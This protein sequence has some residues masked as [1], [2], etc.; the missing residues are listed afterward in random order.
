MVKRTTRF[1]I[2]AGFGQLHVSVD[3]LDDIG[4]RQEV[5]DEILG[6]RPAITTEFNS[7]ASRLRDGFDPSY[8]ATDRVVLEREH[9]VAMMGRNDAFASSLNQTESTSTAL[10]RWPGRSSF[11]K[12]VDG[13]GLPRQLSHGYVS[14]ATREM[15]PPLAVAYRPSRGRRSP[16]VDG[17]GISSEAGGG[18]ITRHPTI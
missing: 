4:A 2:L 9:A 3:N 10:C 15:E 7:R 18:A 14:T 11:A 6:I 8:F 17:V 5:I 1:V 16:K 12:T 13:R